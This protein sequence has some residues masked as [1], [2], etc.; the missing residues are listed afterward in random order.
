M[1]LVPPPF[2]DC[3]DS[4]LDHFGSLPPSDVLDRVASARHGSILVE[5]EFLGG[6][7]E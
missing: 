4:H 7:L 1:D 3:V 6:F 2:L 5:C